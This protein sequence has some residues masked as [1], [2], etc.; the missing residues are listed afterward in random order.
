MSDNINAQE[1]LSELKQNIEQLEKKLTKQKKINKILM[2]GVERNVD[3]ADSSYSMIERNILLQKHVDKRTKELDDINKTLKG[4]I[5]ERKKVEEAL[6]EQSAHLEAIF[7]NSPI[8]IWEEDFSDAYN[9]IQALKQKGVIDFRK[10]FTE[11]IEDAVLCSS[12]VKILDV[13]QATLKMFGAISKDELLT[14]LDQIFTDDSF[15]TFIEQLV[16]IAENKTEFKGECIN[17]TVDGRTLNVILR[18][19]SVPGFQKDYSRV[20][21]SIMDVTESVEAKKALEKAKDEAEAATRAKADFLASMSHEIRTPM[22]GVIGM[23]G[24]LADTDLTPEQ[25]EYVEIIRFSGDSLLTIINDILDFSKIES[26]K[27]ELEE[28]PFEIRN[29][30][31]ET[32]DLVATKAAKKELDLLYLIK[33]DVPSTIFGDVTRLRQILVNLVN[34]SIKFTDKGEIFIEVDRLA[35]RKDSVALRFSVR[36]TGIGIPEDKQ[37]RLFK[38]FSQVDSSTTRKYGGTGLGL[39]ICK[40]LSE[41]MGGNI[42]V[43]SEEGKGSTFYFTIAEKPAPSLDKNYLSDKVPELKGKQMLI[44]DDNETN[45]MILKLQCK[46]WGI[47]PTAVPSGK[48]ALI[49]LQ[50]EINF[51]LAILDMQMPEMDGLQLGRKIRKLKKTAKLPLLM[52][53]SLGVNANPENENIIDLFLTKPVKQSNLFDAL[54]KCLGEEAIQE[55]TQSTVKQLDANLAARIPLNILIAEDNAINQ[56]LAMKVFEKLGYKA[57]IASNG[58]EVLTWL[59][60]RKFDLIFMDVQMPE[61]DGLE[62]TAKIVEI[63]SENRPKIIAMTANAM[64][65]DKERCLDAGMDDYISKPIRFEEINRVIKQWGGD[66]IN[67]SLPIETK[68][69]SENIMDWEIVDSIR[70]LDDGDEAGT[71]LAELVD[72]FA[73]EF[74]ENKDTLKKLIDQ[75]D[76]EEIRMLAHKMKGSSANLGAIEFS[77]LC[78]EMEEKAKKGDLGDF[79]DLF[80]QLLEIYEITQ[81]EFKS[82]LTGINR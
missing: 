48:E 5:E 71:L 79:S 19:A 80:D 23:T 78:N 42:W 76:I 63:Y 8:S 20:L 11:N 66:F 27:M 73:A 67:R 59:E 30:I 69:I 68:V 1:H 41:L 24:L 18:W 31:E 32:F 55:F 15:Q 61:M 25:R 2:E 53:S 26:Q 58:L 75:K 12:K 43:E 77:K 9:F 45:R 17:K 65:G 49:E 44:V 64:P 40:Q 34:N 60:K 51:D 39:A 10:H 57:E 13:N 3:S 54:M 74:I 7:Q 16:H 29:C 62:A 21:V 37:N 36:D 56:K 47:I 50:K 33:S 35:N 52:L 82:Y 81:K 6:Q 72:T 4:E 46:Q 70:D 38:S 22:N 14:N 28:Q